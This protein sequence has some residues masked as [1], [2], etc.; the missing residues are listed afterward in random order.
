MKIVARFRPPPIPVRTMDWQA[1]DDDTYD[2]NQPVGFGATRQ[3]AINE[4]LEMLWPRFEHVH[5]DF[6]SWAV[7]HGF[8]PQTA[9]S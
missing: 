1:I 2:H 5:K 9:T 6:R 7:T 4:L 8:I 3:E